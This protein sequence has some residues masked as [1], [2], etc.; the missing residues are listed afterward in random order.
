MASRAAS[1]SR[2][3]RSSEAA[4][5]RPADNFARRLD[6]VAR[7]LAVNVTYKRDML[8]RVDDIHQVAKSEGLFFWAARIPG[9]AGKRDFK[10]AFFFAACY[11][12]GFFFR[13]PCGDR[14]S[15]AASTLALG[16]RLPHTPPVDLIRNWD[17]P[18][19]TVRTT[20]GMPT[21]A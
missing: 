17:E 2:R 19:E 16:Y 8:Q 3:C 11:R 7:K 14:A 21:N 1:V 9:P 5:N 4:K 10:A 20:L 6:L 13:Q 18:D 15:R 12:R